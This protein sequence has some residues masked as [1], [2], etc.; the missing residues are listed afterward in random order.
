MRRIA[1]VLALSALL[2]AVLYRPA[3]HAEEIEV[4]DVA[5]R[6]VEEGLALDVDF[7]F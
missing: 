6:S 1:S 5:R 4:R 3:A 7:A 2:A